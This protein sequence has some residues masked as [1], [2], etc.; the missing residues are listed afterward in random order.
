MDRTKPQTETAI[1]TVRDVPV[2]LRR[3][4]RI[5]ALQEGKTLQG[6]IIE[7]MAAYVAK[8]QEE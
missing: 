8:K 2:S 1:M 7:L 6:K 3:D 5:R 4:V